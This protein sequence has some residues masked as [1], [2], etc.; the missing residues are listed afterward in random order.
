MQA[1]FDIRSLPASKSSISLPVISHW[2]ATQSLRL[3]SGLLFKSFLE[4]QGF[5]YGKWD[6]DGG[7]CVKEILLYSTWKN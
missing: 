2:I 6:I 3:V 1:F 7:S 5:K 4:E